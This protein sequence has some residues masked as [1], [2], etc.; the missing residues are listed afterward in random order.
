MELRDREE[1]F[2][3]YFGVDGIFAEIPCDLSKVVKATQDYLSACRRFGG[4]N[5]FALSNYTQNGDVRPRKEVL[6]EFKVVELE[7][8][9]LFSSVLRGEVE[10]VQRVES[11]RCKG[12]L[13]RGSYST[14]QLHSDIWAGE[15]SGGVVM[16]PIEGDFEN[17]GV[18]FFKPT[19]GSVKDFSRYYLSYSEVPDFGPVSVGKMKPGNLYVIDSFCLHQ[20]MKGGYR[21]SV[22]FRFTYKDKVGSD[23]SGIGKRLANYVPFSGWDLYKTEKHF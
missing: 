13:E 8:R 21:C 18:E 20:T 5:V 6:A 7:A 15:P 14:N 4:S 9:A 23:F 11:V 17:G 1:R 19:L 3:K 2:K 10:Q 22:D 16:I 12:G